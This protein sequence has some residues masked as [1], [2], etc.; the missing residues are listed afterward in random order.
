M[1]VSEWLVRKEFSLLQHHL[2]RLPSIDR[3]R[4]QSALTQQ[5]LTQ[6]HTIET[7]AGS[8]S[9]VLL[10]RPSAG[11]ARTILTKQ[12]ETIRWIEGFREGSTFWDIGANVGIYALYAARLGKAH[13]LAFE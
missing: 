1:K 4:I 13:V 10:G 9:F 11:R 7:P 12:P 2:A 6:T 3:A 8:L 5:L